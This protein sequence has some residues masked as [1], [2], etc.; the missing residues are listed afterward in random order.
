MTA[1]ETGQHPQSFETEVKYTSTVKLNYLL[2]IP[3][4]YPTSKTNW[5][6]VLFLHGAGERGDDLTKIT[7]HGLPQMVSCAIESTAVISTNI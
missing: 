1:V 2:Y 7:V 4:E 6:L 3:D 5:P